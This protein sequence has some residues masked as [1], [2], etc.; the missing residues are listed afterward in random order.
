MSLGPCSFCNVNEEAE[1]E[2]GEK[3]ADGA[4]ADEDEDKAHH[5]GAGGSEEEEDG[6][7]DGSDGPWRW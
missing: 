2:S 3:R 5:D 4:K 1:E 7:D 6:S